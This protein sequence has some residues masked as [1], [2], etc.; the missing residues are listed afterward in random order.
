M[1]MPA[2]SPRKPH[3]FSIAEFP[4]ALMVF[5]VLTFFPLI[6]L[7]GLAL[8]TG[9]IALITSQAA[10]KAAVQST[11]DK[12]LTAAGD[13]ASA[14]VNSPLG[15]FL[16]IRAAGGYENRGIDLYII[17]SPVR[18]GQQNVFG[19][20]TGL[21]APPDALDYV[22]E[23]SAHSAF[24]VAPWVSMSGVPGLKEVPGLGKPAPIHFNWCSSIENIQALETGNVASSQGG[25]GVGSA[26]PPQISNS[27]EAG[28]VLPDA[29]GAWNYPNVYQLIEAAGQTV[30]STDVLTIPANKLMTMTNI[31]VTN[32]E[33]LWFTFRT[34]GEWAVGPLED[35]PVLTADGDSSEMN[36]SYKDSSGT[37]VPLGM[38]V[39]KLTNSDYF[40]VGQQLTMSSPGSGT[41]GLFCAD[42]PEFQ[43]DNPG[44]MIVRVIV[45]RKI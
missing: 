38:L 8:G 26:Q 32:D 1:T 39:G 27:A 18:G 40:R 29:T 35:Y 14:L 11:Y 44:Q 24:E 10:S 5:F 31:T 30:V 20:N 37:P 2:K 9:S 23:Y 34:D 22:Y 41:L 28:Q 4:P 42:D 17:A 6:N 21:P 45:T 25:G 16:N 19:P 12:S 33:F 36:N 15:R 7:I 13:A 43:N 3:G